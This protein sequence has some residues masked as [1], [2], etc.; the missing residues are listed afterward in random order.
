MGQ[1]IESVIKDKLCTGCG[2]CVSLCPNEALELTLDYEKGIYVPELN[3]ERCID[4]SVCYEVCPGS[5]IDF[6]GLSK[7]IFGKKPNNVLIGSYLN[8]Y[9]GYATDRKI[10]YNSASG[11]LVTQLL[12]FA[13]EAGIIDGAL[14]TRMKTS[15]TLKPE[16]FIARTKNEI[17]AASKSK[18]CPVPANLALSE[19]LEE[20]G[21]FAVVGLPCHIQGVRKAERINKKLRERIVLHLGLFCSHASTFWATE[22]FLQRIGVEKKEIVSLDYRGE[23]WPGFM[24]ILLKDGTTKML[25]LPL[26]WDFL[27]QD[28]LIPRR[29]LM[30]SDGLNELADL[31][32]GD[33]WLPDFSNDN[34]GTSILIARSSAG[35]RLLKNAKSAGKIELNE[36]PPDKVIQSQLN[37]LYFKKK[38]VNSRIKLLRQKIRYDN[39][40]KPNTLD[41]LFALFLCLNNYIFSKQTLRKCVRK[42]PMKVFHA[43]HFIPNLVYS[44][45]T[46]D[47]VKKAML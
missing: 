28:F 42:I 30:C 10:R 17:I 29:C 25:P 37:M 31:S 32:F 41:Y 47:F 11:G 19:I 34:L 6:G 4:C 7:E 23:G 16:P 33:A 46:N 44:K 15:E 1:T 39:T 27:G 26:Y 8:C 14:V 24:K 45:M 21:R 12:I 20:E 43:Y 13:L 2:T 18:Y 36:I 5:G 3:K 35:K 38:N 9:T 40:L 22:L